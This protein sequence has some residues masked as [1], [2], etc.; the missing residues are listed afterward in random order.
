M[1]QC[2]DVVFTSQLSLLER[3]DY[4]IGE[5]HRFEALSG[6][7][8][9]FTWRKS[10][11]VHCIPCCHAVVVSKVNKPFSAGSDGQYLPLPH[12]DSLAD[13]RPNMVYKS[14][15]EFPIF[16]AMKMHKGTE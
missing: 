12:C 13:K 14:H 1:G 11:S 5:G 2:D 9:V 7:V 6:T 16:S 8:G 4:P 10:T 15:E 3:C